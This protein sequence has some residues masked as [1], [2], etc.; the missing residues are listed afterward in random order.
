M[1]ALEKL[2]AVRVLTAKKSVVKQ[3]PTVSLS[4]FELQDA[5]VAGWF[6]PREIGRASQGYALLVIMADGSPAV[7][8]AHGVD[9][10]GT[11]LYASWELE[12]YEIPHLVL[13]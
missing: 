6:D 3:L 11:K 7:M 9:R 13:S 4:S 12:P 8:L 10:K 5:R 1:L 2:L